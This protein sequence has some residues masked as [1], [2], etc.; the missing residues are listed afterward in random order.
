VSINRFER[1]KNVGLAI[2]ALALLLNDGSDSDNAKQ[3]K[4]SAAGG[5]QL[6]VAG[7]ELVFCTRFYFSDSSGW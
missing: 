4:K 7:A 5:A 2:Q 6:V 1:K 3:L